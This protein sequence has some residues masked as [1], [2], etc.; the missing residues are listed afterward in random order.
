MPHSA[1]LLTQADLGF[2]NGIGPLGASGLS[3][4]P[5]G[6]YIQFGR[7]VSAIIGLL[8]IIAGIWFLV[9]LVL[10]GYAW[11][12]SGGDKQAVQIAQKKIWNA[13]LGLI[14]VII[15]YALAGII[16]IILGIDILNPGNLLYMLHP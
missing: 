12:S 6:V 1:K 8:T 7:L 5:V 15:S 13:I 16:G 11:I 9:Q 14:I 2:I 10:G 3:S 4:S